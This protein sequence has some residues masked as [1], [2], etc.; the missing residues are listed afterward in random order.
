[1]QAVTLYQ[2]TESIVPYQHY[3]IPAGTTDAQF[4][5]IWLDR[6]HSKAT[7]A[8]YGPEIKRF[9]A[10]V[11]KP[12]CEINLPDM[13]AYEASLSHCK[14]A[15]IATKL[16][17]VKSLLTFA[18]ESGYVSHINVGKFVKPPQANA[19]LANRILSIGDVERMISLEP[20]SRNRILLTLLYHT[21][22]RLQ[23]V[24]NLQWVDCRPREFGGQIRVIGKGN[25]ERYLPLQQKEWQ[26]LMTLP[27]TGT[28]VFVSRLGR[29]LSRGQIYYIVR[30]AAIQAGVE[31]HVST[32]WLRHTHATVA[33]ERGCPLP[34]LR[35]SLGHK[36]FDTTNRYSHARPGHGSSEFIP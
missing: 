8:N 16:F 20:N 4:V 21:G 15:T 5:Q 13:Q 27:R 28:H 23:E 34:L 9:L 29:Q 18:Y 14:P 35:D 31:G 11:D 26:E 32:H 3:I 36:S 22:L 17:T 19:G 30:G 7:Q 2:P 25:R 10:F 33:L 1:M 12:L 6:S 24:H